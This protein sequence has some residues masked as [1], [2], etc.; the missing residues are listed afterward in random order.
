M[1]VL[2]ARLANRLAPPR[3]PTSLPR[4]RWHKG[5]GEWENGRMGGR[6]VK[7]ISGMGIPKVL[8]RLLGNSKASR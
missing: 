3:R 6:V 8:R 2:A 7:G 4:L 5:T 1:P